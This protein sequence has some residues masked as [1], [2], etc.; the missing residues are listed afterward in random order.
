MLLD[1]L[2]SRTQPRNLW[3][4]CFPGTHHEL[5]LYL[6]HWIL[7][8]DLPNSHQ[9]GTFISTHSTEVPFLLKVTNPSTFLTFLPKVVPRVSEQYSFNKVTIIPPTISFCLS[10]FLIDVINDKNNLRM[11]GFILAHFIRIWAGKMCQQ[12]RKAWCQEQR[13]GWPHW[14]HIQ[15]EECKQEVRPGF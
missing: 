8:S 3:N 9:N 5:E 6:P 4:S 1:P 14:I 12:A 13:A 15:I 7:T 10:Y 2:H 11:K